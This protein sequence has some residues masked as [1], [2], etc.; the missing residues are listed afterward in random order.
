MA[1]QSRPPGLCISSGFTIVEVMIALVVL[2]IAFLG[3]NSTLLAVIDTNNFSRRMMTATTLA[4]DKLEE[5]KN[6]PY[7]ALAAG[8]SKDPQNPLTPTGAVGG[9]YTR[10]WQVTL[11]APDP[12]TKTVAVTVT[13]RAGRSTRSVGFSTIKAP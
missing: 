8:E 1:R 10:V 3:L 2:S 6:L 11:D 9:S 12:G 7:D 5:L 4:Q 13:W